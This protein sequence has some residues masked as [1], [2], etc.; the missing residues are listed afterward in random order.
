VTHLNDEEIQDH[1]LGLDAEGENRIARHLAGCDQCRGRFREYQA[2]GRAIESSIPG[3]IPAG[4]EAAVMAEVRVEDRALRRADFLVG[5]ISAVGLG[6]I[7]LAHVLSSGIR[8]VTHYY[9]WYLWRSITTVTSEF[10][11][12]SEPATLLIFTV[13]LFG[14]FAVVD[15]LATRRLQVART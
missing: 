1:L 8:A 6:L 11:P 13:A 10:V 14:V 15:R 5:A 7:G 4:F 12:A 9:A 3:D 2:V